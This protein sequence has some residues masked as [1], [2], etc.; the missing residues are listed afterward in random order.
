MFDYNFNYRECLQFPHIH[1]PTDFIPF[2]SGVRS[3]E[4]ESGLSLP[5][6]VLVLIPVALILVLA[7]TVVVVCCCCL[8]HRRR[9]MMAVFKV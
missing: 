2:K 4:E 8:S 9:K 5:I 1:L 7:I 6:F 3:Q